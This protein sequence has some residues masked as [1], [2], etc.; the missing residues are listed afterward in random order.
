MKKINSVTCYNT[1]GFHETGKLL[2]SSFIEFWPKE[3]NL[4]VYVDDPIPKSELIRDSRVIYKILNQ[5]ELLAFK[6]RHK[7]NLEANGLGRHSINNT[8][9]YRYDAV[10]FSHK[11]FAL[12]QFL[13][14]QDTDMLIWLDGD[15]R[16]HSKVSISDIHGWCPEG[17]FAGYL[18]RPWM[19]TETGFHAF[20]MRH[21]ISG[22]FFDVWKQYYVTDSIF[23]LTMWTDCHTYD[24]AK[25]SFD[26]IHWCNL[27]PPFKNNHPFINGVLGNFMDHMKGPRKIKGSSN[28]KDLVVKKNEIYWNSIK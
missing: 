17:K 1:K 7:N 21:E 16:T 14:E 8:K 2:I 9:N 25:I 3:V 6:E 4:T 15:S 12:I 11:V 23:D 24:A 13:E 18:A 28:K 19:Y 20:N 27:S 5:P 26:D 22:P 10:R